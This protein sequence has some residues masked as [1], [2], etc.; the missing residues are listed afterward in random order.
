[1]TGTLNHDGSIGPSGKIL[2]KAIAAKEA[3]AKVFLVPVGSLANLAAITLKKSIAA[4]G[5]TM[6]TATRNS[7]RR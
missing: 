3:G 1:M 4:T 5:A 6:S 7:R 2:E